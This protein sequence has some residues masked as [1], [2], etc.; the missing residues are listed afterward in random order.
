M[1]LMPP[2]PSKCQ[3]CAV[4]HDPKNPHDAQ[5]LYYQ[6]WFNNQYGRSPTWKD[7]MSHCTEEVKTAFTKKLNYIGVD[8]N[9]TNL[10]GDIKC[11]E[12]LELKLNKQKVI[13]KLN[14]NL[15]I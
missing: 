3:Y 7:A 13:N 9:S 6:F 15:K 11:K 12:D 1:K 10:T 8:V 2:H 5:S 4:E 14:E